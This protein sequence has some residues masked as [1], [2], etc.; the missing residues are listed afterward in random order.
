[1]S[2]VH[3]GPPV[4]GFYFDDTHT[5]SL[6]VESGGFSSDYKQSEEIKSEE[7]KLS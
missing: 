5:Q 2:N 4:P 7:V 1:M 3:T 6:K